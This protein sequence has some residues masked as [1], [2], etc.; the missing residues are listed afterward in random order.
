[1]DKLRKPFIDSKNPHAAFAKREDILDAVVPEYYIIYD[2]FR[3]T[4]L[5][6]LLLKGY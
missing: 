3:V 4:F 1:M 5:D 6:Y 2:D